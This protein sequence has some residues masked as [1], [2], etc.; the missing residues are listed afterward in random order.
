MNSDNAGP[1][2]AAAFENDLNEDFDELNT[3]PG[4]MMKK[5]GKNFQPKLGEGID[6][7][8][9]LTFNNNVLIREAVKEYAMEK[10]IDIWIKKNDAK[11]IVVR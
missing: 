2:N 9:T 3:P 6:F 1:T 10:N 5:K 11:R 8:L 7:Q 4:V